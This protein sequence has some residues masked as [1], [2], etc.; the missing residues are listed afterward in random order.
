[1]SKTECIDCCGWAE[2]GEIRC[3]F[4]KAFPTKDTL[5]LNKYR[6]QLPP[7]A[8]Y[9]GRGSKWGN[10]YPIGTQWGNR[11]QVCNLFEEYFKNQY[12]SG[13]ISEEELA[14]LHG[15]PLVC[16]CAPAR[17]HGET[18]MKYAKIAH[19]KLASDQLDI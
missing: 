2:E 16:F 12:E 5:L 19:D 6:D 10:P 4:H 11:D 3:D 9:I 14:A 13:R 17:C 1:M 8:E 15:K 7:H 18:I